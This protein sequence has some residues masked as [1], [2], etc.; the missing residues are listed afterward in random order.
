MPYAGLKMRGMD[1]E[2][3]TER[4][5]ER[6]RELTAQDERLERDQR[7]IAELRAAIGNE[8]Q[9]LQTAID[10]NAEYAAGLTSAPIGQVQAFPVTGSIPDAAAQLLE[11]RGGEA[12]LSDLHE[13]LLQAGKLRP[14][15]HS[16]TTLWKSL[17]RRPDLFAKAGRGRWRLVGRVGEP[18]DEEVTIVT[19]H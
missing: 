1:I 16:R 11:Q 13:A 19:G 15:T 7:A 9:Q 8:M 18:L 17:D 4:M 5:A 3:V 12:D 6:L 2:K 10:L 14:T